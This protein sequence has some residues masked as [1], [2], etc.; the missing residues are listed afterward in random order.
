MFSAAIIG[1]MDEFLAHFDIR[2]D[3]V[4]VQMWFESSIIATMAA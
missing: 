2:Y 3:N 1:A 4:L